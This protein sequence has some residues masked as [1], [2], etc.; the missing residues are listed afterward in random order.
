MVWEICKGPTAAPTLR[1]TIISCLHCIYVFRMKKYLRCLSYGR[2][3][4][5]LTRKGIEQDGHAPRGKWADLSFCRG[6]FYIEF[7]ARPKLL[8]E[9]TSILGRAASQQCPT[10]DLLLSVMSQFCSCCGRRVKESTFDTPSK[11]ELR[12]D[13][14]LTAHIS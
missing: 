8:L 7:V 13:L 9:I 6:I 11:F 10:L 12:R 1:L 4:K 2:L 3:S 14:R 5:P